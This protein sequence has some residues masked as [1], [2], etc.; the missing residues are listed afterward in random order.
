MSAS[1]LPRSQYCC[2][3]PAANR[4]LSATMRSDSQLPVDVKSL[5]GLEFHLPHTLAGHD[6][7]AILQR[8]L[9]LVAPRTP[10]A[11]TIAVV[12]AAQEVPLRLAAAL[13]G[14]GN[15]NGLE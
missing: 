13:N 14:K 2:P 3:S 9:E 6:A 8:R 5:V 7:L 12:V 4:S 11:V 1:A 10:P 15:V